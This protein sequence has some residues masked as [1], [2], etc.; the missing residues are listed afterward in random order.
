MVFTLAAAL[1]FHN[2]WAMP[3]A[4]QGMQQVMFMKNLAVAGG[5]L[6]LA[7][8]GPGAWSLDRGR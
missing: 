3:A 6:M 7:V 4:E 1:L 5:L 8:A 2:F